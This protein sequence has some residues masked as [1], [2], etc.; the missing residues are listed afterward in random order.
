MNKITLIDHLK[1][2]ATDVK[3]FVFSLIGSIAGTVADN[4]EE[5]NRIK[6]DKPTATAYTVP[7]SGWK[8]DSTSGYPNYY[9]I[10]VSGVTAK[11]RA[12]ITIKYDS[13]DAAKVCG[14]CPTNETIAGAIRIRAVNIPTATMSVEYWIMDG[15]G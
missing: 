5:M 15:K 13:L 2:C 6:A 3:V 1:N 14:L 12:E 8:S 4:F 10:K 7:V 11:D 9:D